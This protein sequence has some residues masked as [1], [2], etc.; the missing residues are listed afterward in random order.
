MAAPVPVTLPIA[1]DHSA[2]LASSKI[3]GSIPLNLSSIWHSSINCICVFGCGSNR[4]RYAV[5][6]MRLIKPELG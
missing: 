4:G 2:P 6:H 5:P 1:T 3:V